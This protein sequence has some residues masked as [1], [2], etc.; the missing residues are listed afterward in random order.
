MTIDDPIF[1]HVPTI[2]IT[3][4]NLYIPVVTLSTED[5]AKLLQ[6]VKLGFKKTTNWNKYQSKLTIH[7]RNRY[8]DYLTDLNFQG[9]NRLFVI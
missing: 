2:A 6:Q 8:L 9:L 4:A 1:N 5:N 3:N 7:E